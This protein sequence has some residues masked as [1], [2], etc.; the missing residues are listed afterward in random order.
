[1]LSGF[2]PHEPTT[3]ASSTPPAQARPGSFW[4]RTR[5]RW[6]VYLVGAAALSIVWPLLR[7]DLGSLPVYVLAE[8]R[9]RGGEEVFAPAANLTFSYP[10]AFALPF[11]GAQALPMRWLRTLAY[12]INLV[13]AAVGVELVLRRVLGWARSREG[14]GRSEAAPSPRRRRWLLVLLAAGTLRHLLSPVEYQSHDL[15]IFLLVVLS[16]EAASRSREG[17]AGVAAGVAAAFKVTPLLL[18]PVFAAQ[19]RARAAGALLLAL[20]CVTAAPEIAFPRQDG[21]LWS[22]AWVE[23]FVLKLDATGPADVKG[24]WNRWNPLN[25]NLSGTLHRLTTPPR[26]PSAEEPDVTLVALRPGVGKALT[27]AAQLVVLGWLLVTTWRGWSRRLAP[28]ER[29]MQ[30][31]GEF[32]VAACAMLLLSPM[33]SKAHFATLLLPVAFCAADALFRRSHAI[34]WTAVGLAAATGVLAAKDIVGRE[35]GNLLLTAGCVTWTTVALFFA[36]GWALLDRARSLA[37]PDADA[38]RSPAPAAQGA[39]A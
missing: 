22:V 1:M 20:A 11:L 5:L 9:M 16:A 15:V 35:W 18:L 25:Q 36:S 7:S 6:G 3:P 21:R 26:K 39:P 33:S 27:L 14:D 19:G 28:R 4:E 32:G 23:S 29:A 17:W 38:E 31:W 2:T 30:R 8:A 37:K 24:T 12:F 10:A 34:T 13:L